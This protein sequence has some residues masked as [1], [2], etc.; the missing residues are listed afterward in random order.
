MNITEIFLNAYGRLRSGFRFLIF[1][2]VFLFLSLP[3]TSLFSQ[4]ISTLPPEYAQNNFVGFSF[5]MIISL[6]VAVAL[7]A[8]CGYLIEDLPVRALGL[9]FDKN[10]FRDLLFGLIFGAASLCLAA[11]IA[12]IFGGLSF[13]VNQTA[14]NPAILNT[15]T[16][17][18]IIFALGAVSEEVIF[19][20]YMLQTLSRSKLAWGGVILTS[21]LFASA[22]NANPNATL[23][24]WINTFLAGVWFCAGYLKTRTLW[25]P[26]ALHFAW[27]WLQGA[28][29]GINVSGLKELAPAPILQAIDTGPT[30][31]TGGHYGIEG[32]IACTTALIVSTAAIWFSPFLKPTEDMLKLTDEEIPAKKAE[33]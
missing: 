9:S 5:S 18:F 4:F 30:W 14:Q 29:L 17:T 27:N 12:M 32:G 13:Q 22:H 2:F 11:A 28:V 23:F 19:R 20:G 25:F 3:L 21:F 15:L 8:A 31:L 10:F 7:G 6:S 16:T 1:L 26:I 33:V 24:S